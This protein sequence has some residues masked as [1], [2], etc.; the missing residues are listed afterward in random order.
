MVQPIIQI[1]IYFYDEDQSYQWLSIMLF[2]EFDKQITGTII[3]NHGFWLS[4]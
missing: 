3:L 2:M 4:D 1:N